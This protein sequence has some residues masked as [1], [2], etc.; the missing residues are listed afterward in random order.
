MNKI[1]IF[2]ILFTSSFIVQF[3]M[4]YIFSTFYNKTMIA[5]NT[6]PYIETIVVSLIGTFLYFKLKNRKK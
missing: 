6:F 5:L 4:S 2:L 3:I 1:M